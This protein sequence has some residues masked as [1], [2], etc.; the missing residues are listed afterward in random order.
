MLKQFLDQVS[1]F[2]P[3]NIEYANASTKIPLQINFMY[4]GNLEI[5]S[6]LR[7]TA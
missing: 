2:Y 3:L 6:I 7:H 1:S 5:N 4:L